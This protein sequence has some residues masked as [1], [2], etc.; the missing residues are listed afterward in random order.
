MKGNKKKVTRASGDAILYFC[1]HNA[2]SL[3]FFFV[4]TINLDIYSGTDLMIVYVFSRDFWYMALLQVFPVLILSSI[5]G[6]LTAFI[7]INLYCNYKERP[8][9]RWSELNNGI[10]K[11][12]I[13][14]I[15]TAL[16]T[17]IVY[18]LGL[19][20]LLQNAIFDEE[21]LITLVASYMGLK[22]LTFI[23]IRWFV[24]SKL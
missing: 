21:T 17:S 11:I 1:F 12:G 18:S 14:F 13:V 3:I 6:R 4:L 19:I 20:V 22:L 23:I 8:M 16:I 24:G 9:K 5:I 7:T 2:I 15:I 10:N